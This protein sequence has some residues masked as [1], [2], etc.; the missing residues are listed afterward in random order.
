[1]KLNLNGKEFN[2]IEHLLGGFITKEQEGQLKFGML[3]S[4]NLPFNEAMQILQSV[5]L[6]LLNTFIAQKP[7]AKEDIY[8]AYN[9][10]ASSILNQIIPDSELR[11]DLTEEAVLL[12]EKELIEGKFD[13]MSDEDKA[14]ATEQIEK[15]KER[16][17]TINADSKEV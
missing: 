14:K 8:D 15:L 4:P 17:K 1:M 9:F 7:E 16:L 10:M 13:A 2:D 11:Y 6:T 12:A 3:A 5:T